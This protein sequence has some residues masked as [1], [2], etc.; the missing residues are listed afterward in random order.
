MPD[1][2]EN[3]KIM[4]KIPTTEKFGVNKEKGGLTLADSV[5]V[6]DKA[7]A[8]RI[9]LEM[10]GYAKSAEKSYSEKGNQFKENDEFLALYK[11]REKNKVYTNLTNSENTRKSAV[12]PADKIRYTKNE[13]G[14]NKKAYSQV[15]N[16]EGVKSPKRSNTGL[17]NT[18]IADSEFIEGIHPKKEVS[19]S[20]PKNG[21]GTKNYDYSFGEDFDKRAKAFKD[22]KIDEYGNVKE[23]P[24]P[25]P[26]QKSVPQKVYVKVNKKPPLKTDNTKIGREIT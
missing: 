24:K 26:T 15:E 11:N 9:D 8:K 13:K 7:D 22:K 20:N 25:N 2:T 16:D 5:Y 23:K 1:P 4:V 21:D 6:K 12:I 19:Y 3:K 17:I 10:K 14:F 18:D